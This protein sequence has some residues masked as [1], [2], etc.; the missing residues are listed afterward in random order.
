MRSPRYHERRVVV[1]AFGHRDGA[2]DLVPT[3]ISNDRAD[4]LT[5][6]L[7]G[8]G[9]RVRAAHGLGAERPL[10]PPDRRSARFRNERVEIW[11]I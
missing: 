10:A 4:V 1:I 11:V 9:V 5:G 3:L 2:G 6:Y 8:R 7:Q